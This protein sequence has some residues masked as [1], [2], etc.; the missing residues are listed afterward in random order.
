MTRG[1][2]GNRYPRECPDYTCFCGDC[3]ARVPARAALRAKY[4]AQVRRELA[5]YYSRRSGDLG[6]A[7]VPVPRAVRG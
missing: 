3:A 7:A 4:T 5:K 1:N 6:D 2:A